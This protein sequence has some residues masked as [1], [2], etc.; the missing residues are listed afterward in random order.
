MSSLGSPNPFMIAGKQ[1]YQIQRSLRFN[2]ADSPRLNRTPSSDGNRKTW[3]LSTWFKRGSIDRRMIFGVYTSGSDVSAIEIQSD[4]IL[5]FYDYLSAYRMVFQTNQVLRDPSAWYHLV[6]A[7]DTTQSTESDRVKIYLNG[8]QITS[9]SASTYPSQNLDVKINTGS[10][11]HAIGTEGSNQRLHFDGYMAEFN[12]IDGSQLTPS[13]FA[14]T[15][16]L[17]GEYKPKKYTGSYGTN[18][19]Y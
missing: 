17:T 6:I 15:D 16:V 4:H 2:S 8:S 11:L 10:L 9:F 13:S 5:N 19:F 1:S 7:L 18:G 3:T 12:F 14:E